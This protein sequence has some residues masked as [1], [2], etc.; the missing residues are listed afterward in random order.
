MSVTDY[1]ARLYEKMKAEQDKYRG[2]LL[3]QEPSEILNHTYEYI[4][5][6]NDGNVYPNGLIS[7]AETATV[8]FRLLKDE[9][10]DGNLLTS[11][12][13]SDVPDDYWANTAIS[14]MTGLGIV[15]GHSGTAFDPGAPI[16]RAQFAAICARFDTGAGGTTQTFSDIS[17]HWAE[18]YIRRVAGLGWIKGFEDGT[19]RPDAYIT[20]A[21]AMTMINRVLNRIPEENSDLPAGMNTW[22]DCNPGDWFS[23]AVQEATNSHAFQHKAGNYETWTG[24][25]KKPTGPGMSTDIGQ[26]FR[27]T[28]IGCCS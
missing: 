6:H 12:T 19:F 16:T 7:R 5:G 22:P 14:T 28:H 13:Y 26:N 21:Q 17:G 4:V 9:V 15:Q 8:F 23:L 25:N 10:R 20:R 2:W 11:N 1:N 3:H 27:N 24:M 18:E